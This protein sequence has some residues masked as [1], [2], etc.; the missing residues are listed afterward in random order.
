MAAS[1]AELCG[2]IVMEDKD[3]A[4]DEPLHL[5]HHPEPAYGGGPGG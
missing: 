2:A 3:W 5:Q 4:Y 1:T